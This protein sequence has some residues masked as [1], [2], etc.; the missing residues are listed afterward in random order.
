[1]DKING[2]IRFAIIKPPT[3]KQMVAT[4]DGNCNIDNP[5]IEWPDV[6]PPA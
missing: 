5:M 6:Q 3:I 4:K 1:M 2:R